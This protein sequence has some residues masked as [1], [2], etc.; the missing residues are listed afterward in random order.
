MK[1]CVIC[2]ILL[3]S[4]NARTAKFSLNINIVIHFPGFNVVLADNNAGG[5]ISGSSVSVT[6]VC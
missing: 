1:F 5:K 4:S 2:D 3:L 6:L